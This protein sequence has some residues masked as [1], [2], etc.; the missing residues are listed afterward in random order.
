M[1]TNRIVFALGPFFAAAI[2]LALPLTVLAQSLASDHASL[3]LPRVNQQSAAHSLSPG[4]FQSDDLTVGAAQELRRMQR[5]RQ[6]VLEMEPEAIFSRP[7]RGP[8]NEVSFVSFGLQGSIGTVVDV[9]GA[10]IGITESGMMDQSYAQV[11]VRSGDADWMSCG[12]HVPLRKFDGSLMAMVPVLTLRL[13]PENG[14]FDVYSGTRLAKADIPY[15]PAQGRREITFAAGSEG[16]WLTGLVQA[17]D[18]PLYVD[19]N[20]NGVDDDFEQ[21]HLGRTLNRSAPRAERAALIKEWHKL[22]RALPPPALFTPRPR[23]DEQG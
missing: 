3:G 20:A 18:N 21:A 16:A 12:M 6:D 22:E 9:G 13:D 19:E 15:V 23:P 8:R 5:G 7:L 4:R 2:A 14:A 11:M 17:D 10:K 1:R